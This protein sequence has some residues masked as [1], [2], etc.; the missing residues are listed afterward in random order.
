MLLTSPKSICIGFLLVVVCRPSLAQDDL[1]DVRA[2][3]RTLTPNELQYNLIGSAGQPQTPEHGYKLLVV[4]PGG[5]GS[6]DFLPFVQRIFKQAL[7]DDYL[8][9]Q[10][11][12][13]KWNARQQIV[14]PTARSKVPGQKASSEEFIRSAVD[15]LKERVRI[16][17]RYVFTLSWSSGGPAAYA[18]SLASDTP[19]TGSFVAMS[20]FKPDQLPNLKRAKGKS[21]Y[22]FH[23]PDDRVCPYWMAE[24]ARDALREA[25]A[26]VEFTQYAG[27][28][29][30]QGDVFG[31]IRQGIE[32]LEQQAGK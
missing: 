27:G 5:D 23:S 26:T 28:H 6:A 7:N 25:E 10:L 2:K 12:A 29:G 15:D 19:I 1:A 9:I 18:A 24:S 32:W 21:Y 22:I 31:N 20:V 16:D 30:W 14:W 3:K 13:P 4:L 8:I 17:D 11:I